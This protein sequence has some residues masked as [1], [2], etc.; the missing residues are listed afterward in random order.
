MCLAFFSGAEYQAFSGEP[1]LRKMP[2]MQSFPRGEC[3]FICRS[4]YFSRS[5]Q[6]LVSGISAWVIARFAA[7]AHCLQ[8]KCLRVGSLYW[9]K[10]MKHSVG[11][12][13]NEGLHRCEERSVMQYMN[14]GKWF[15]LVLLL[16]GVVGC[17]T[18][19]VPTQRQGVDGTHCQTMTEVEVAALF[20]RWNEALKSGDPRRVVANY[21]PQSLLLPTMSNQPRWTHE[22]REDYFHH[23]LQSQPVGHIEARHIE[24]ACNS[25][26]DTGLYTFQLGATGTA[27]RARYTFTYK[28]TDGQW[29][30]SSHHSSAMPER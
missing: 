23:F 4:N 9:I 22:E 29:L 2:W 19:N 24:V 27:V 18:S 30:I 3:L 8:P 20:D 7:Q 28:W 15:C 6:Y 21:A 12:G 11:I 5:W 26:V 1:K 10:Y 16:G 13:L 25:A 14:N 17:A